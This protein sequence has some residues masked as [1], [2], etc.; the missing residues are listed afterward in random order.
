M[1][2]KDL[3]ELHDK[4]YQ[5]NQIT[6]EQASDDLVFYWVTQWDDQLL[7]DS[8]LQYRGEFNVLRKAGRQI[9]SDL[10]LNPVQPDFKPKDEARTD[11]AELIDGMYRADDHHLPTQAAYDHSKQDAVVCGMGS[12]EIYTEYE[13]MR[14][15]DRNQVIRRRF[16]PESCN[17]LFW[18]P[19]SREQDHSDA[20]YCS[21]LTMYSE[22]GYK[23]LVK[24][25]T[26]EDVGVNW[27]SFS[28][29]EESY[30]FPW[31]AEQKKIYVATIYVREKV[32]D[33]IYYV[34]DPFGMG[35]ALSKADAESVIDE[36]VDAGYEVESEKEVE[37]W[38]VTKY[39]CSGEAVLSEE[40][41]SG[42]EIPVVT[43]YGE[44]AIIEGDVMYQGITR[45]AK[46]PQRLRNFQLSYLA[47]ICSR[48][49]RP[50]PIFAAEQIQ[51][52][53]TM[54]QETGADNNY[55]YYLQNLMD[56]DGNALP[57]GPVSMMPDQ[58]IPQALAASIDL[59]RQAVEDVAN[60]GLA[61][62]VA[63]PDISGKAI[64]AITAMIEK[65][66]YIY[67]H[68]FKFAK[69]RDAII[70]AS[71]AREIYDAPRRVTIETPDGTRQSVEIM[72]SAID[73]QTGELVVLND[74][75][76]VDF[77]VYAEIGPSYS[78]QKEQTKERLL[79]MMQAMSDT[80][81][82]RNVLMLT[83]LEMSDGSELQHVRD[84]ARRQLI[85]QG[86]KEPESEKEMLLV[87]QA[88]QSQQPDPNMVLAEA[89][90]LKGQ[91]AL[92]REQRQSMKDIADAQN[93]QAD[94]QI[95]AFRAQTDRMEAMIKARESEAKIR[96]SAID[97]FGARLDNTAKLQQMKVDAISQAS[98]VN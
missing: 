62:S 91:A 15:G 10:A 46:D 78:T 57:L 44:R 34:V 23:K 95:D 48:S 88:Q 54:Y 47:D 77:D 51:G 12:W 40:V 14:N 5:A 93:N 24:D 38:Q 33:T 59:S 80:D 60:P 86:H 36:L 74:L 29:P 84:F 42:E 67:Q 11:E 17:T 39:I 56:A 75:S 63:D 65:Q 43:T 13:N 82:A 68:N 50:K 83:L 73:R 3:K 45:L 61:Q 21:L 28:H 1:D 2:L 22:D 90:M 81:P 37:R 9:L 8:Q 97:R 58:P 69:R 52:F 31:V 30:A 18:D 55:P 49:P 94:T 79:G 96:S 72:Q 41:I 64:N 53:E 6:R 92:Q 35:M 87:M 4:A 70:Y 89:E 98:G 32:N 16:I 76:N 85:L 7:S 66:S 71:I 27:S 20:I 25:L 26:G 19:N